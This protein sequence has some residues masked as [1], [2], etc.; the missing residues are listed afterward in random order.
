LIS[1]YS[2]LQNDHKGART[3]EYFGMQIAGIDFMKF[4]SAAKAHRNSGIA[5]GAAPFWVR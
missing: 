4:P 1:D 5:P 2:D 3:F